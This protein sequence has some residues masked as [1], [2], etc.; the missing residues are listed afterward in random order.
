MVQSDLGA[1]CQT[2]YDGVE[3][4]AQLP[5]GGCKKGGIKKVG[6]RTGLLWKL[7]EKK[8]KGDTWFLNTVIS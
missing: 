8:G 7:S 5:S 4:H 3:H 1:L 2:L 6:E